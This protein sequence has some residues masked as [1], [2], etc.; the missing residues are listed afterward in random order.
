MRWLRRH[1][2]PVLV[3]LLVA[4]TWGAL[5]IVYDYRSPVS[6]FLKGVGTIQLEGWSAYDLN[7]ICIRLEAGN[8]TPPITAETADSVALQVY[9]GRYV[10]EVLLVSFHNTCTGAA[11]RLAWAVSMSASSASGAPS[12]TG[13]VPRAVVIL[14]AQTG[15]PITAHADRL[16]AAP[17]SGY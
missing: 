3:V 14:D 15:Q 9:P 16:L 1:Q 8:G 17:S 7:D 4:V 6:Q 2:L 13:S 10:R 11:P 12:P 5:F